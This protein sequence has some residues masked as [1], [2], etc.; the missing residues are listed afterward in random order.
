M[1]PV[2]PRLHAVT[3]NA[4]AVLPNLADIARL[5][6]RPGVALHARAPGADG[7]RHFA[8]ASSLIAA[9]H[10]RGAL[11]IVNDRVDVARA[12]GA[13]GVHLP[14]QGLP[15][16]AARKL[17]PPGWLI[18]CS[19]HSPDDARRAFDLGADYVFL[20][21][22]WETASH[23]GRTGLGPRVLR[24]LG[25]PVIAIGGVTPQRVRECVDAGAWG[26]A[27]VSALWLARDPSAAAA[28]MLIC[29]GG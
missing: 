27:A 18:G 3:D 24:G 11:A 10:D 17:A 19:T 7:S 15:P 5:I 6:A 8:L 14:G 12:A 16:D 21:P 28:E 1:T 25:H 9:A 23:A 20:G 4:V 29:L 22:I 2:L 13:D 26:V